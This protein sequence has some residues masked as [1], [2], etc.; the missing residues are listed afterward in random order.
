M[1]VL[2]PSKLKGCLVRL[3]VN[4]I[5]S[6][7]L[8]TQNIETA[9][10]TFAGLDADSHKGLTRP[11]CVR[12][13]LQYEEGTTIR[14]VRQLTAIG[15]DELRAIEDAMSELAGDALPG[16]IEPEWL[17]ANMLIEGIPQLTW[18][19]PNSRLI[20]DGGATITID[21]ENEPCSGPARIIDHHYPGFGKYFVKAAMGRRGVT[22]WVECE[23]QIKAGAMCQLHCPPQRHYPHL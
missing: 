4:A 22:A 16:P 5:P 12:T 19:P 14:N 7:S 20:F 8:A 11:A 3:M 2:K 10:L 23:G 1:A 17:G 18:L 9:M 13:R 21:M 6:Q 15:V